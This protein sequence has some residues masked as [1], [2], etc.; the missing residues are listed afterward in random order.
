MPSTAV[1]QLSVH[2]GD[3]SLIAE[4]LASP[5][6]IRTGHY[7]LLS[8]LHTDTFFAFS[9]IARDAR[10]IRQ[11]CAW[12]TPAAAAWEPDIVL[13]PTTAG[14]TLGAGIA[15]DLGVPLALTSLD[16]QGR[17]AGVLGGTDLAGR[18]VVL[19]NDVFTTG[20]GLR[21]LADTATSAGA[22]VVGACWFLS[23]TADLPDDLPPFVAIATAAMPAWPGA[24]CFMCA[25]QFPAEQ[26]IDLN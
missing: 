7:S 21:L 11:I 24:E 20:H 25:E 17:A 12:L 5:G 23:R 15:Q 22:Q 18:R 8:G 3:P 10:A 4:L 1:R 6:A 13:A 2:L 16:H 9:A 26:A 14:V 19:V